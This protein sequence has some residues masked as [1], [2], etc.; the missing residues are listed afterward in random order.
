MDVDDVTKLHLG[1][2][3]LLKNGTKYHGADHAVGQT[4]RAWM[5]HSNHRLPTD[6]WRLTE[7]KTSPY[8]L[9]VDVLDLSHQ[10]VPGR[11]NIMDSRC[12]S[13]IIIFADIC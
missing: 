1:R 2:A 10:P 5:A 11:M 3:P 13:A 9:R 8:V 12:R 6:T 4:T 7:F